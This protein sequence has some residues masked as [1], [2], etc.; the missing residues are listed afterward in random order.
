MA[1]DNLKNKLKIVLPDAALSR[2]RA[3]IVRGVL[4]PARTSFDYPDYKSYLNTPVYGSFIFGDLKNKGSNNYIDQFGET[5][6]YTPLKFHECTFRVSQ[7]KN[8]VTTTLQGFNG[9]IKEYVSDGDFEIAIDGVLSGIYNTSTGTFESSS[10]Y[11]L[12]YVQ[13]LVRALRIPSSIPISNNILSQVFNITDVVVTS[14]TFPR[15]TAG[16]N[17]QRFQLNLISDRPVEIVLSEG[18]LENNQKL[19]ELLGTT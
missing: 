18:D 5:K 2:L 4:T 3:G 17:Y 15:D 11:P 14:Y 6:S 1:I 7:T 13:T 9:T 19:S 16:M 12:D 10:L 8:I